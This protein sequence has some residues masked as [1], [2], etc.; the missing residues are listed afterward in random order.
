MVSKAGYDF[1]FKI[2]ILG[3]KRAGK[4]SLVVRLADNEFTGNP[5]PTGSTIGVDLGIRLV[6][7][8]GKV[9]KL[10]IFDT[11]GAWNPYYTVSTILF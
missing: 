10:K 4:S 3:N 2:I 11:Y 9:A 1:L 7:A 6:T 8:D 5:V